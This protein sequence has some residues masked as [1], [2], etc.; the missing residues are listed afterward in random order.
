LDRKALR[1][2]VFRTHSNWAAEVICPLSGKV[3]EGNG[4]WDL[5]EVFV[6]RSSVSV[7]HQELIMVVENCI[8]LEHRAHIRY[9]N[10]HQAL[11]ACIPPMFRNVGV[12]R[13]GVWY[14]YLWREQGLSMNKGR[15]YPRRELPM[16]VLMG[17][18]KLGA[19]VLRAS[20]PED[21][22]YWL[23]DNRDWRAAVISKS[24]GKKKKW[25]KGT[26][27]SWDGYTPADILD[28]LDTGYWADYMLGV[29]G[30][31]AEEVDWS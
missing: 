21:R 9:G 31:T 23:E 19:K 24:I 25:A 22:G 12:E 5:H 15:L 26:P 29:M 27:K 7:P 14:A 10:T 6:K 2:L 11:T 4:V 1:K 16:Y 13:I 30:V 20:M 18:L 8:P 17:M 3:L 28:C